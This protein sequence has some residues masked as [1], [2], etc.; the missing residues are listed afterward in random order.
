MEVGENVT[1]KMTNEL[2]CPCDKP[3]PRIPQI[4]IIRKKRTLG[5]QRIARLTRKIDKSARV[6]A[7]TDLPNIEQR[8][9][10]HSQG[11]L[12]RIK[13]TSTSGLSTN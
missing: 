7:R 1:K 12:R 4:P 8:E 3:A 11:H 2:V 10:C 5:A 9:V 6:C 13:C